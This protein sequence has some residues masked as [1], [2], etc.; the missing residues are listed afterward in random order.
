M[1]YSRRARPLFVLIAVSLFPLTGC[2]RSSESADYRTTPASAAVNVEWTKFVDEYIESYFQANPDFAVEAGRHE[3]DGQLR[4]VSAAGIAKEIARLEA[5]RARAAGFNDESMSPEE[6]FQREYVLAAIDNE[7]FYLREGRFPF[8]NPSWYFRAGLDPST[9]VT[10]PYAPVE[11]RARAFIKYARQIPAYAEH[12]RA[13]LETPLPRTFVDFGIASFGGLAEFY[14]TDAREAFAAAND[15]QLK[16]EL[17]AAIDA[18][19][20]AMDELV[21]WL[22]SERSR[23][24]D[25]Y[26]IGAETFAA[27]LR[28]TE[29]VTT[30][31]DRLEEIGRADLERN[32]AALA[33]ACRHFAGDAGIAECVARVSADKPEGG[34]VE[35]AREQLGTLRQFL[36]ENDVVSI[37]GVEEALVMEAPAYQRQNFAYIDIPG[38]FEEELPSVYYIAPPDPSW[39]KA[40]QEA[41]TPG[42]ADLMFTSIHE[43]WPGHF[44]QFLHSN[45]APWKF[46]QLFVGYAFAEGWAHYAEELMIEKGVANDAPEL[47]VG[48]LLNA[49][50]RNVRYLCAIGLHTQGMT[51][52]ECERMFRE[53][54]FQDP[55]NARQQAARGAYD[56][57]YL[58][59][60]L[61]KLMIRKLRADWSA[62]RGGE[63]AW[64]QFHDE[65]LSF[66]GPPIPLV[67]M[68]MMKG[69]VGE[70]F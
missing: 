9:Y 35:G 50:L 48:Q 53:K 34:A 11:Q 51:V 61:G 14:R 1:A 59:Y 15:P 7:L 66:G 56:P 36:V 54:A 43:V 12:I 39:S 29:R 13:N 69:E 57:G 65:L 22:E 41:Y 42:K 18:A 64:R 44:L 4:D 32:L 30:P 3:F 23:A 6:R 10:V 16:K 38:P 8:R 58:N 70:L 46:G 62:S 68:Q 40:E 27:M 20:R 24:N 60:T 63:Q 25:A 19:A 17:G 47:H 21:K 28:M 31:L 49:L 67:R 52:S 37:P 55:G 5:A 2:D 45:R 33:D 26:A